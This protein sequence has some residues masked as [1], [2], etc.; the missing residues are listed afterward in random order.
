MECRKFLQTICTVK[1]LPLSSLQRSR[2]VRNENTCNFEQIWRA[3]CTTVLN[4]NQKGQTKWDKP[5]RIRS[6]SQIFAE[7]CW[8]RFFFFWK[9]QHFGGADF[10]RKPHETA[11]FRRKP[12]E[13]A[14]FCRKPVCPIYPDLPKIPVRHKKM[15]GSYFYH[16]FYVWFS[17]LLENKAYLMSGSGLPKRIRHILQTY[18]MSGSGLDQT[19]FPDI[20]YVWFRGL[21]QTCFVSGF[22]VECS[23]TWVFAQPHTKNLNSIPWIFSDKLPGR[24]PFH[25]F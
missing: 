4:G 15:S 2:D 21:N 3:I 18:F 8:F 24:I 17:F 10:C 12:Q 7:F 5:S 22:L 23:W 6:F 11:D 25:P 16:T 13:T 9:W 20:F 1:P 14:E 19:Y